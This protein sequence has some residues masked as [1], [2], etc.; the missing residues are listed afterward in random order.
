MDKAQT[1]RA[2]EGKATLMIHKI[3]GMDDLDN[4]QKWEALFN[5]WDEP[6]P[7]DIESL[8]IGPETRSKEFGTW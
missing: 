6:E 3:A 4:W 8:S 7:L 2:R 5:E 1:K